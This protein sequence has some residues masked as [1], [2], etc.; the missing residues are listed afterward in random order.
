MLVSVEFVANVGC[1]A[2]NEGFGFVS[3]LL[4]S[5]ENK[6]SPRLFMLPKVAGDTSFFFDA[7]ISAGAKDEDFAS[8]GLL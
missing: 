3:V 5:D 7:A 4:D 8:V 1:K 2:P 6:E